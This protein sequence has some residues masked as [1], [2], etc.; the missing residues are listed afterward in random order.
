MF[1]LFYFLSFLENKIKLVLRTTVYLG[2]LHLGEWPPG[3][4]SPP[5]LV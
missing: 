3:G 2:C 1:I 4:A 5:P